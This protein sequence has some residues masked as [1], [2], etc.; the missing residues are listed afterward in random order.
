[1]PTSCQPQS[2]YSNQVPG[3]ATDAPVPPGRDLL[4]A[5]F[6]QARRQRHLLSVHWELTHRCNE[7]CVHCYLQTQKLGTPAAT[8]AA[9]RELSTAEGVA[10]LDQMADMGVL[11]VTFSGG[12]PLLRADFWELAAHARQRRFGLRV[13]TNGW[14]LDGE[15]CLRQLALLHPL[16][17]EI[18][19]YAADAA[20]HDGVTGVPGS[21]A[22][23]T[24]ALR[25]LHD[26]GVRTVWKTP[27]LAANA[28]EVGAM[29]RMAEAVG[30]AFR[31][32]PV[33]TAR[34]MGASTWRREPLA[35]R[36]SATQMAQALGEL[37]PQFPAQSQHPAGQHPMDGAGKPGQGPLI[38]SLGR[39]AL[40]V[41]PYGTIMPCVEVRTPLGSVRTQALAAIWQDAA[42]WEPYLALA[43]K[44]A[45]PHCRTC[46]TAPWC[47]RC[48]GAAANETGNLY[49][50]SPAHCR[51]A[52]VREAIHV[53]PSGS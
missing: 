4:S 22:R 5:L 19:V 26:L 31:L 37:L 43:D 33:L 48:H 35:L 42:A 27:L 1:V 46:R 44:E 49:G 25:G 32:D 28:G 16:T 15:G 14:S 7:R 18:S 10:L 45:L 52:Q 21:W 17:V 24:A 12:E 41:D 9:E 38:C 47:V 20:T 34:A 53:H 40:L 8:R 50:P 13:F 6:A 30:A 2:L 51:L 3:V 23:T 29:A 11:Q 39:S 36:A